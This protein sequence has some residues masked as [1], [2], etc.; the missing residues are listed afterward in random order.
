MNWK[1]VD[2]GFNTGKFNMDYDLG[3]AKRSTDKFA[4]LR[5]FR[6]KPYCISLGANQK[7]NDLN[8]NLIKEDNLDYVYRPTGGR[9]ILHA[10]EL[11]YS[12]VYPITP[13]TSAK[14]LYEEINNALKKGLEYYN[15]KL[16]QTEL[17]H[18]QPYFPK[19]YQQEKSAACFAVSAK[20][21]INFK[22]RKLIGSAQRKLGNAILQH[23]SIL[24][25]SYHKKIIHYLNLSDDTRTN[26]KDELNSTT[27]DLQEIL[28]S[29]INYENLKESI[30]AGFK[31]HFSI[32][33]ELSK[34]DKLPINQ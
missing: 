8:I 18:E 15:P 25:G 33:S 13:Q 24:C 28:N 1:I 5:L 34:T 32:E 31:D 3:L 29:E 20:S 4:V 27:I 30:I 10:E 6:W 9:A 21:E 12:V 26:L 19:F 16:S 22:E 23:G 7:I 17:E 14:K 11:T 2:T